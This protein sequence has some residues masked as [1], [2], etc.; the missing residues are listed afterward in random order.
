MAHD[1]RRIR[2]SIDGHGFDFLP[3]YE[4]SIYLLTI[5][6]QEVPEGCEA[7]KE[8]LAGYTNTSHRDMN[9]LGLE[10]K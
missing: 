4:E 7:S 9:D 8:R 6:L 5:R 3:L 2:V 10:L 1:N